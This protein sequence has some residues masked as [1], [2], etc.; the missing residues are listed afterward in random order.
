MAL[1]EWQVVLRAADG[2]LKR[3]VVLSER[4]VVLQPDHGVPGL[5]V[6]RQVA[7][8]AGLVGAVGAVVG[9]LARVRPQVLLE[10][11]AAVGAVVAVRAQERVPARVAPH[12]LAQNEVARGGE[13][14][15]GAHERL[16][17]A[18]ARPPPRQHGSRRR[19][20]RGRAEARRQGGRS[21][22]QRRRVCHL[23]RHARVTCMFSGAE[24]MSVHRLGQ[25]MTSLHQLIKVRLRPR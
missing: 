14:A 10:V 25:H 19:R 4:Q 3:Q 16:H 8:V 11:V 2:P 17:A 5:E 22:P 1:A 13:A 18:R 15:D 7:G 24:V 12:V 6:R 23:E 9:L 21:P 20:G